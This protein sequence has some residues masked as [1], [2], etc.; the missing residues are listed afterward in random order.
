[1][2]QGLLRDHH[3]AWTAFVTGFG[4][5]SRAVDARLRAAGVVDLDV[6]DVLVTL[7]TAPDERL[8][9]HQLA[10]QVQLTRSGISRMVD[11]LVARGFLARESCAGDRRALYAKLTPEGR[12]AREAAWIV[13]REAIGDLFASRYT[14]SEARVLADLLGRIA[15]E[16]GRYVADEAGAP[17][18]SDPPPAEG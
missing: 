11:R 7:E 1:M 17:A 12:A 15:P 8:L 2:P 14:E 4:R 3:R 13:Q 6:Y 16:I 5:T 9:M 18:G 10:E